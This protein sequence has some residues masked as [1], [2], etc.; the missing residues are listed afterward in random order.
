MTDVMGADAVERSVIE[1]HPS[2]AGW[3]S[4]EMQ[5]LPARKVHGGQGLAGLGI[6]Y[7]EMSTLASSGIGALARWVTVVSQRRW[8]RKIYVNHLLLNVQHLNL[9]HDDLISRTWMPKEQ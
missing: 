8:A 3:L 2:R 4:S 5:T 1:V 7:L 6:E 9:I